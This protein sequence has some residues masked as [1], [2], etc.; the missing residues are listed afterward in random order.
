MLGAAAA[1]AALAGTGCG[2]R[3]GGGVGAADGGERQEHRYG[4]A[5]QQVADLWLPASGEAGRTAVLVHGGF[6]RD[7]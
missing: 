4:E 7:R 2:R 6:W 3:A 5:E 1:V